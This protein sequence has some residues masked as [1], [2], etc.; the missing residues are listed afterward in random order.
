MSAIGVYEGYNTGKYWKRSHIIAK[1]PMGENKHAFRF[2][3]LLNFHFPLQLANLITYIILQERARDCKHIVVETV[4]ARVTLMIFAYV[5]TWKFHQLH[6]PIRSSPST[7]CSTPWRINN[8]ASWFNVKPND[9][10]APSARCD[11]NRT[12]SYRDL[13]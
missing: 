2:M 10:C 7:I 5:C 4:D 13:Y 3:S 8:A 6:L 11:F 12:F 9:I 1:M